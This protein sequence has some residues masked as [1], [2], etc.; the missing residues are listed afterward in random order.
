M[1]GSP[2]TSLDAIRAIVIESR[3]QILARLEKEQ[4]DTEGIH[5]GRMSQTE[6]DAASLRDAQPAAPT[7]KAGK[8]ER[9]EQARTDPHARHGHSAVPVPESEIPPDPEAQ[10]NLFPTTPDA[11]WA[12]E[13]LDMDLSQITPLQALLKL[14]DWKEKMREGKQN[15]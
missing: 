5:D 3:P 11:P 10:L 12:A 15:R 9:S 14:N 7:G 1:A 2:S 13:L 8:K 4:I 6:H